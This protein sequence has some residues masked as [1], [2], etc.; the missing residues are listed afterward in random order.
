MPSSSA[1]SVV[2]MWKG[3]ILPCVAVPTSIRR[4]PRFLARWLYSFS[5]SRIN[6]LEFSAA[7]F[8]KIVLV[9]KDLP[10]PDLPMITMLE[11]TRSLSRLKKS[12]MTGK[13]PLVPRIEPPSSMMV[14]S[15]NGN[16]AATEPEWIALAN[17]GHASYLE[18]FEEMTALFCL[19]KLSASSKPCSATIRLMVFFRFFFASVLVRWFLF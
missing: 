4:P 12:T 6:I 16:T 7:R 13:F 19:Q 18:I 10:D 1:S 3:L 17:S 8:V 5:G 15:T 2:T 14:D 9:A 11:F